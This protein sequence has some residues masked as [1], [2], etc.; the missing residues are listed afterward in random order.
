ML[1]DMI[2]ILRGWAIGLWL[3]LEFKITSG[4]PEN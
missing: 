3:N 2:R 1:A 4:C